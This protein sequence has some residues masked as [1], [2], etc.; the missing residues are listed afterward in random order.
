MRKQ[1][2]ENNSIEVLPADNEIIDLSHAYIDY[3]MFPKI[4]TIE[5]SVHGG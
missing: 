4:Y 3:N 5:V 2:I 1:L